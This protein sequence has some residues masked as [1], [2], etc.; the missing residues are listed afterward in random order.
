MAEQL[1]VGLIV[2]LSGRWPRELP[3]QRHQEYTAWAREALTG[4]HMV[5]P[6]QVLAT[7]EEVNAAIS[8]MRR[9]QVD[10][11]VM[12][13]G[14]FT[15]DDIAASIVQ[16]MG[17]PLILWA[18]YEPP[19]EREQRLWANAL[20]AMTM[21]AA[22]LGRLGYKCHTVYGGKE[23]PRAEA[24]VKNLLRGYAVKKAMGQMTLGLFGYRPTN[25]YVSTFDEAAIR[26]A[27]G[28]TM[29]AT[30]LKTV[31]DDMAALPQAEVQADMENVSRQ[32]DVS[33]LPEGHLENHS[34]LYLA[35][36][37]RMKIDG[38]D[39]G[40][41]KCWP[42]MGAAHTQPCAVLGR[43]LDDGV[44]VGCEGDVDAGITQVMEMLL[45]PQN[46]PFI[47]DM[48]DLDETEN[49]MTFWHCGNAAP[50]LHNEK[51]RPE[52][53]NHPLVGQGS[54]FWTALKPGR[55]TIARL[56]NFHGQ[57][58]LVLMKGE[59]LDRDRVTR[60][61]M[62][63]VRMAAPVRQTAERLIEEEIPHHYVLVWDDI[64]DAMKQTA[65]LMHIPVIEL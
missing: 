56:H 65:A 32:W 21:N 2:T 13:Y 22:A 60:G 28:I 17:V 7:P 1:N 26:H 42:E 31:F 46:A 59:A 20:C 53:R 48:I 35:L 44:S 51:Y 14:A 62:T 47:T 29:N 37:K 24:K 43:L 61:S 25:Y 33:Q 34:R 54:A 12:V 36:K 38:Y 15:G 10:V 45:S 6:D 9:Q 3:I 63:V 30:E 19:Y 5:M 57:Y 40:I 16:K 52:L 39:F 49:T 27:F 11:V 8:E 64:Y 18:P 50:S 58:K 23:D 41:I 4:M 55:V